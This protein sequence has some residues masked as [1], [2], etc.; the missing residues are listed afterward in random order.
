MKGVRTGYE[1]GEPDPRDLAVLDVLQA[2]D[3]WLTDVQLIDGRSIRV[4]NIAYDAGDSWAHVST[5]VSPDVNGEE[6]DFFFT[7]EVDVIRAPESGEQLL[8]PISPSS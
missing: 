7:H 3:G 1:P 8:P 2:R 6:F 4:W 5:N